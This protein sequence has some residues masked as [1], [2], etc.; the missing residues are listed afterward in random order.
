MIGVPVKDDEGQRRT[1]TDNTRYV[2]YMN[3]S[4]QKEC[5]RVSPLYLEK[6]HVMSVYIYTYIFM[7]IYRYTQV[8]IIEPSKI[9]FLI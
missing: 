9:M 7:K 4:A 1:R 6:T 2:R 5:S 8:Y 3:R